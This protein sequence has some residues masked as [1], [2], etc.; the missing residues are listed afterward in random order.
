MGQLKFLAVCGLTLS[1]FL[2]QAVAAPHSCPDGLCL[3]TRTNVSNDQVSRE[4]GPLLS[5][6]AKIFG[7]EDPNFAESTT[8]FQ[9]FQP[10][11]IELVVQVA[12]E[13]DVSTAISYADRNSLP[14]YVTNRR[15]GLAVSQG[16][17]TGIQIDVT[18]L[19]N[20]TIS[21]DGTYA[22]FQG[23]TYDQQVIEYLW[24]R[25]YV[26]T[27]GSCACVGMLGPGLGGGHGRYQGLYGLISDNIRSLNVVLANGTEIYVSNTSHPD[28][29]WGMQGAGHNFGAVTS[30]ELNIFPRLVDT[31]YFK[32]Y[33]Y[34]EDKLEELFERLNTLDNMGTQPAELM[35]FG[36][37]H[38]N[39]EFNETHLTST[40][41]L[42]W[43]SFS[44]AGPQADAEAYLGP[45]DS[46][47]P[48]NVTDGN[49]PYPEALHAV[50]TGL[51]D[52]MCDHGVNHIV[53]TAGTQLYNITTQRA[54]FELFREKIAEYPG[55]V[56]TYVVM[57]AYSLGAVLAKDPDSSAF[58]MRD[59]YLLL[60][61]SANY[62]PD[63]SLDAPA[64][65]W[66]QQTIDLWNE[67]QPER[68]PTTYVNYGLGTES[69]ESIY[70]YEP[71]RLERLRDLKRRYDPYNKFR[72]YVPL[73]RDE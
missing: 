12:R 71:W 6:G 13:R 32:N 3:V 23:G 52:P 25:G 27:T 63:P 37:F 65:E 42:I 47:G 35:N 24:E 58:P 10:P 57:E 67:G 22:L 64:L 66:A 54:V 61:I 45:F 30:F 26:T 72:Y 11:N 21:E 1:S 43:W 73:I 4:L 51:D 55:L 20:I 69:L 28:L 44:Y 68:R 19:Q 18:Q 15:H 8:R 38:V 46:L 50:G 53:G 5:C 7:P 49:V 36:F 56:A 33:L 40:K 60:Q 31:W 9:A 14:F 2:P 62:L 16:S 34:T 39:T 17:F 59:D 48:I 70:G 29:Y 41:P